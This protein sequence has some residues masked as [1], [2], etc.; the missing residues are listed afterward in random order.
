MYIFM[1]SYSYVVTVIARSRDCKK[2]KIH[3][4]QLKNLQ[5]LVIAISH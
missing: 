5:Q 1:Y 4:E 2:Y 3:P